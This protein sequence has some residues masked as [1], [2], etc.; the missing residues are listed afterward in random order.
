MLI[1]VSMSVSSSAS[2]FPPWRCAV[3]NCS[4]SLAWALG[5][6]E[7]LSDWNKTQFWISTFELKCLDMQSC[8][9]AVFTVTECTHCLQW[10]AATFLF[11]F[12]IL[13]I[14]LFFVLAQPTHKSVVNFP[15]LCLQALCSSPSRLR[16]GK[17][18]WPFTVCFFFFLFF[19]FCLFLPLHHDSWS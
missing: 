4:L 19:W 6:A 15:S 8:C 17:K 1:P 10:S 3:P 18:Y 12:L 9:P 5:L 14:Y 11:S 7:R 13:L 16:L 2:L